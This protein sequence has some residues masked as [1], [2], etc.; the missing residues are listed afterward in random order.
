MKIPADAII[1][2][3]KLTRYLL[4]FKEVDDKSKFLAQGG[5]SQDNP[6]D[7]ETAL[8]MLLATADAELDREN[9][10]GRYY[11]VEGELIGTNGIELPITT[12]WLEDNQT[13]EFR[14]ITLKPRKKA[15]DED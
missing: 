14:F 8:R 9:Q 12:I 13:R 1:A 15:K 10:Y 2:E 11:Q 7:L 5:F 6:A 4:V 3:A